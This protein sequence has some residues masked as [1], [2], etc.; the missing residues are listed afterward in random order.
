MKPSFFKLSQGLEGEAAWQRG[1]ATASGSTNISNTSN[2]NDVAGGLDAKEP[3]DRVKRQPTDSELT[4][5]IQK[6]AEMV[7]KRGVEFEDMVRSRNMENQTGKLAFLFGGEG[8][9]YY[10]HRVEEIRLAKAQEKAN[11]DKSRKGVGSTRVDL[12]SSLPLTGR[13]Y[14]AA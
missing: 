8:A 6:M 5:A 13:L 9:E 1:G 11:N 10:R 12:C 4:A 2:V 3:P 7:A 14:R